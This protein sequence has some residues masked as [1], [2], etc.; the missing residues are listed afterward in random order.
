LPCKD[1]EARADVPTERI[2]AHAEEL[3]EV[4][5]NEKNVSSECHC[6]EVGYITSSYE[7]KILNYAIFCCL[8]AERPNAV[9]YVTDYDSYRIA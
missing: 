9:H 6:R 3:G 8:C 5:V 2:G 4:A 1:I 7:A